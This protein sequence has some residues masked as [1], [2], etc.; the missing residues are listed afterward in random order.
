M[1]K[2]AIPLITALPRKQNETQ[3]A[4]AGDQLCKPGI[5]NAYILPELFDFVAGGLK[6]PH[7][8]TQPHFN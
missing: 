7:R 8:R 4:R 6:Q 3:Q 1:N 2:S 5:I